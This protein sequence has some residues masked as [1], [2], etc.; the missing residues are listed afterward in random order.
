M[1]CQTGPPPASMETV[2]PKDSVPR[3]TQHLANDSTCLRGSEATTSTVMPGIVKD[4]RGQDFAQVVLIMFSF[5]SH[6][7]QLF[8]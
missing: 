4:K 6:P 7:A 1:Q 2:T 5:I 8:L 3:M